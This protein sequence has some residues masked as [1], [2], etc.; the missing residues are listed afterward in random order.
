MQHSNLIGGSTAAQRINC[1]GSYT[2]EAN[3]PKGPTSDFAIQGNVFHAAMELLL[4]LDPQTKAKT[5]KAFKELV[6]QDLGFGP[7]WA[8]TE[9]QVTAKIIP[10]W[11]A[12]KTLCKKHDIVDWF[13]E[14]RV[15]L[16][17]VVAGAFGTVDVLAIDKKGRLWI[18]DWKFGD[19]VMVAVKGNYQ[20]G[21]YGACAL[22]DEDPELLE[23]CKAVTG[24]MFCII[25][26]KAD[27]ENEAD[28]WAVWEPDV[29][30]IE[31]LIDQ[32]VEAMAKAVKPNAPLKVGKHC[33]WCRAKPMCPEYA[34]MGTDAL[35]TEPKSMTSLELS[36]AM[37]MADLLKPWIADVFKLAQQELEGGADIPGYKLVAKRAARKWT[38]SEAVMTVLRKRKVK[39]A[40]GYKK[41]LLSPAQIQKK[42]PD[43]YKKVLAALVESV[44]SGL[45]IVDESDKRPGVVDQFALLTAAQEQAGDQPK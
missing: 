43:L 41:T 35:G 4:T 11:T 19:G 9:A 12:W 5:T 26:P 22:Y 18:I 23:F 45:T 44:S 21:F 6:G 36:T 38:D 1:P 15:T 25:Q 40:D 20:L 39:V 29:A 8:I 17:T 24:V 13:I 16:G 2:L 3:V 14:Q 31:S 42:L 33:R 37:K 34:T 28:H 30:W 32:C 27:T 7:K 10:A